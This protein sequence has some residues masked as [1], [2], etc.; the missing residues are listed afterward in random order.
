MCKRAVSDFYVICPIWPRE[1]EPRRRG[2]GF[3]AGEWEAMV[4]DQSGSWISKRCSTCQKVKPLA[5][6]P[7]HGYPNS[8]EASC[9]ACISARIRRS[10]QLSLLFDKTDKRTGSQRDDHLRRRYG[11]ESK[12][13]QALIDSQGGLCPICLKRSPTQVDH[14]HSIGKV[15]GILCIYCNAAMGAFHDDPALVAK[16]IRY[17]EKNRG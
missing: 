17:L 8:H 5:D 7:R 9:T 6:F 2:D 11:L 3:G 16:A 1:E 4:L 14:D 15:R 12:E 13:V 10:K